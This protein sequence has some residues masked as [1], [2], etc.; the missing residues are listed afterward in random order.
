MISWFGTSFFSLPARPVF[1]SFALPA[2][3]LSPSLLMTS[4]VSLV[5]VKFP[6]PSITW[7][8][9]TGFAT[10][11]HPTSTPCVERVCLPPLPVRTFDSS[12]F[13]KLSSNRVFGNVL[14]CVEQIVSE[15]PLNVIT[16]NL[17]SDPSDLMRVNEAAKTVV[18]RLQRRKTIEREFQECL[19]RVV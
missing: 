9:S 19:S 15:L 3:V 10:L 2:Y 17:Q 6:P 14:F 11:L 18:V 16:R 4:L 1:L 12:S 5:L 13:H 8:S 7:C